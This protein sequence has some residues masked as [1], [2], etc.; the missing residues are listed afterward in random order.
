MH[1]HHDR[2]AKLHRRTF[3][4]DRSP[5]EQRGDGQDRLEQCG[6][7]CDQSGDG[8]IAR[9]ATG[10]DDLRNARSARIGRE[11]VGDSGNRNEH[12]RCRNEVDARVTV[13]RP[14]EEGAGMVACDRK[15]DGNEADQHRA[16]QSGGTATPVARADQLFAHARQQVS[17]RQAGA[18]HG[19]SPMASSR[20]GLG[21][22]PARRAP[23]QIELRAPMPFV[24]K[25]EPV[26]LGQVDQ[27]DREVASC[28]DQ[29]FVGRLAPFEGG[30]QP[31]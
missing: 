3:A 7:H 24:R 30:G 16:H 10:G 13:R 12:Q 17:G 23:C 29:F 4:P 9:H 14:L 15:P 31:G 26:E 2:R 8:R 20:G 11:T 5:A 18:L 28:R 25:A 21:R 19:A 22:N 1:L 6:A 27:H